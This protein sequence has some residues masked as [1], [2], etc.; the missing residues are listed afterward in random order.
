MK[1]QL[2]FIF[3]FI[4]FW[5]SAQ[6]P[7]LSFYQ[8]TSEWSTFQQTKATPCSMNMQ[9]DQ[10]STLYT[11]TG[12]TLIDGNTYYILYINYKVHHSSNINCG[13]PSGHYKRCFKNINNSIIEYNLSSKKLDTLFYIT[14]TTLKDSAKFSNQ[15]AFY[16]ILNI[17]SITIGNEKKRRFKFGNPNFSYFYLIDGIGFT[18]SGPIP[19]AQPEKDCV[20]EGSIN[21]QCFKF[22]NNFYSH[23]KD[24]QN[25]V[26]TI[27]PFSEMCSIILG[28]NQTEEAVNN[29]IV[30]INETKELK[31]N[32]I[33][34]EILIFDISGF[35]VLSN[36]NSNITQLHNLKSGLYLAN[37][38][39]D[40][41]KITYKIVVD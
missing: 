31:T 29:S 12:D 39:F 18:S 7:L 28:I 24:C 37:I 33:A 1:K 41:Q 11:N 14:G 20:M 15:P 2:P 34:D 32:F 35:R 4:S 40:K 6:V 9:F 3:I 17:D 36:S 27:N 10:I 30:F 22:K 26:M 23:T 8:K 19:T 38:F 5:A 21:L 25:Q 13:N 16:R